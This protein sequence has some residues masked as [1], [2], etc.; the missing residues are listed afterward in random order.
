[1]RIAE[2]TPGCIAASGRARTVSRCIMATKIG[3]EVC[4][5]FGIEAHPMSVE[6]MAMNASMVEWINSDKDIKDRPDE[7]WSV[8]SV[9]EPPPEGSN[10]MLT[11]QENGWSGHLVIEIPSLGFMDL[12]SGQFM[13]PHKSIFI[14]D[15]FFWATELP[16]NLSES[17]GS[18]LV[19]QIPGDFV[20]E[21][22][23]R[24]AKCAM[25][26][27]RRSEPSAISEAWRTSPD[28]LRDIGDL[29]EVVAD[30]IEM[31][32]RRKD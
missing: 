29:D 13:R 14:P 2:V 9:N 28:W 31:V 26:W 3:L 17:Q 5:R 6:A 24:T 25:L 16:R 22:N 12:N 4:K 7:A 15:G 21:G 10:V 20:H 8:V 19:F 32:E 27:Y 18:W 11:K 1:M 30:I 23:G